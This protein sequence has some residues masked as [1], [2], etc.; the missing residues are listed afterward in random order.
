MFISELDDY[1]LTS[2]EH[3]KY[4]LGLPSGDIKDDFAI[5]DVV[6]ATEKITL[7]IDI[8][9]GE[10]IK[11]TTTG[12]LPASLV[13]G[14]TYFAIRV[15]ATH[16][17]VATTLANAN[18][19]TAIDLTTV[20]TGTHTITV[21]TYAVDNYVERIINRASDIIEN[22][23][24]RKFMARLYVKERYDGKD[25]EI[26]FLKQYPIIVITLDALV[27]DSVLKKVTRA[28]GGSFVDDGF[29]AADKVL[30]QNSNENSGLLTI[31]TG[32][33]AATILTFTNTIITDTDDNGVTISSFRELWID[34]D[35][36]D[37]DDYI[38]DL[39]SIQ[40]LGGFSKG[41]KNMRIT[42]KAGFATIPD[43]LEQACLELIKLS[44]DKSINVKSESLGPYSV[45]Y[46]DIKDI[47]IDIKNKLDVYINVVI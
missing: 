14:T 47:P 37:G 35:E 10:E 42:Y 15:D 39:D 21:Y 16:I 8:A 1:A 26:L 28:D 2:L 38:L 18:A 12:T 30:I 46:H 11:F 31:A 27:W 25:Q 33:V 6:I 5:T 3:A 29:V 41:F 45:S 32:G 23:C 43:D 13:I 22:Y 44:Y 36:I 34:E 19:G 9:T 40:Y 17:Q 4:Y 20:G 24:H 7:D